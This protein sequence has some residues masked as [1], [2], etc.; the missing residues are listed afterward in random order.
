MI[1]ILLA[2]C[3]SGNFLCEQLDS[4]VSQ[5]V[6]S[7]RLLIRDGGSTD[8]TLEII[9]DYCRRFPEKIIFTGQGKASAKKNF[10]LLLA[11]SDSELIM[12]SDHDDVWFPDKIAV[13]LEE[14][15]K[16][17]AAHP[18]GTPLCVF[19]DALVTDE[20][21]TVTNKSNLKRQNLD[22]KNGLALSRLLVQNVPC[23]NTMLF[24]A[25]LRQLALPVPADIVM[26]DHYLALLC[27]TFGKIQFLD[28]PLLYYRQHKNNVLGSGQ[29]SVFAMLKKLFCGRK[30]IQER[31]YA[32]AE[33]AAALLAVHQNRLPEKDRLL[34]Q[35][36][37]RIRNTNWLNR[38]AIF[39]RHRIW[40]TGILRNIGMLLFI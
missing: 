8:H 17:E 13:S 39:F 14:F 21:L 12:F 36:F 6:D 2:T 37:C 23:G 15:K 31:F 16:L 25:A 32:N 3:N 27:T 29:Y 10:S 22:P 30:F 7:W 4:I 9:R 34:L 19:S 35:D 38:K 20:K 26:H 28:R 40:K 33:Q 11:Q 5:S 18:A 24:N 1:D